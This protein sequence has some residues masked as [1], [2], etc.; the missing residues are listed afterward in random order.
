MSFCNSG[1]FFIACDH[2]IKNTKQVGL[3]Y[4]LCDAV[5]LLFPDFFYY[6]SN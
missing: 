2:I 3:F 1:T 4:C 5:D 6:Q